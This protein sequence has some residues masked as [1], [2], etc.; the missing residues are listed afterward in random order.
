MFCFLCFTS[1]VSFAGSYTVACEQASWSTQ[2]ARSAEI[3]PA[4]WVLREASS[5]AT[6]TEVKS[7]WGPR[8]LLEHSPD[9]QVYA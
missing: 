7:A 8:E 9:I 4:V 1:S 6:Y 3:A 2:A 5:Q